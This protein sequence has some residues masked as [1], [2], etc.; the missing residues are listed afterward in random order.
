MPSIRSLPPIETGAADPEIAAG[1]A[2]V[3]RLGCMLKN[4][5]FALD[6]PAILFHETHPF[7]FRS[8]RRVSRKLLHF[9]R[10][11]QTY[12]HRLVEVL[13]CSTR[14]NFTRLV[15]STQKAR[16]ADLRGRDGRHGPAV[17]E[18]ARAFVA[19]FNISPDGTIWPISPAQ[20]KRLIERHGNDRG[21]TRP[22]GIGHGDQTIAHG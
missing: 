4:A 7:S 5:S 6:L 16:R 21:R 9:Y 3:P 18:V 17:D 13:F 1:L 8:R 11:A 2:N 10:L 14:G 15:R 12:S 20:T 22:K 19:K